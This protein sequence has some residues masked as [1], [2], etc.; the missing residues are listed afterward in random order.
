MSE[1]YGFGTVIELEITEPVWEN[2][3][4]YPV[5]VTLALLYKASP[6]W[7]FRLG[8]YCFIAAFSVPI[9][10]YLNVLIIFPVRVLCFAFLNQQTR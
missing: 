7:S 1:K 4:L 8:S 9:I 3:Q 6:E 5:P 2:V 10:H